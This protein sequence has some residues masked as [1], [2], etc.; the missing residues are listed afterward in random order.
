LP[1]VWLHESVAQVKWNVA[2][3]IAGQTPVRPF[4]FI[5]RKGG[6]KLEPADA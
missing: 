5:S 2:L 1:P 4:V 3:V 6:K